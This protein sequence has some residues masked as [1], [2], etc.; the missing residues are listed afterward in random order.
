VAATAA[1]ALVPAPAAAAAA[2]KPARSGPKPSSSRGAPGA[3]WAPKSYVEYVVE[4]PAAEEPWNRVRHDGGKTIVTQ[5]KPREH[6]P[7]PHGQEHKASKQ[8]HQQHQQ[9]EQKPQKPQQQQQ[10]QD[11][12][13][14]TQSQE[15]KPAPA[16]QQQK[17]QQRPQKPT[18]PT[19]ADTVK[20]QNQV[21]AAAAAAAAAASPAP[22]PV[23]APKKQPAAAPVPVAAIKPLVPN[24][25]LARP[26]PVDTYETLDDPFGFAAAKDD[27]DFGLAPAA[28]ST[29]AAATAAT[30]AGPQPAPL[31]RPSLSQ[32][33]SLSARADDLA[34]VLAVSGAER[35]ASWRELRELNQTVAA[36]ALAAAAAE[37]DDAEADELAAAFGPLSLV[38]AAQ[39]ADVP[40]DAETR[41]R[42]AAAVV[43]MAGEGGGALPDGHGR[44]FLA[45][46]LSG[47]AAKAAGDAARAQQQLE[48]RIEAEKLRESRA[49]AAAQLARE[50]AAYAARDAK[51]AARL[52]AAD[53]K[54]A[55]ALADGHDGL[56]IEDDESAWERQGRPLVL[57]HADAENE[58]KQFLHRREAMRALRKAKS[59]GEPLG[60]VVERYAVALG[61]RDADEA[62]VEEQAREAERQKRTANQI[63]KADLEARMASNPY[64]ALME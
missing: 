3:E 24:P 63:K 42:A 62:R 34:S 12:A 56:E 35:A 6:K 16:P 18:G 21:A 48:A 44:V 47:S 64:A 45:A 25:A 54:L 59:S 55:R 58:K 10:Q 9:R 52:Q 15:S 61:L 2:S 27:D 49:R 30:A 22:K 50:Q 46:A 7:K 5:V 57:Q 13:A 28:A 53:E 37:T 1:P 17:Q 38:S 41:R 8:Q 26:R 43:R 60:P 23:P 36:A 32:A 20:R 31:V 19:L 14:T 11:D 40:L 51:Q 29:A 4:E 33:G 39:L